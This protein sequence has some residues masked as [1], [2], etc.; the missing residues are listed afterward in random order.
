MTGQVPAEGHE[1]NDPRTA[2][3]TDVQPI[4]KLLAPYLPLS[5]DG[6]GRNLSDSDVMTD[7][8]DQDLTNEKP[9]E[10]QGFDASRRVE[11]DAV[12]NAPRWTR[13]I[14][15]LIKSQLLCQ[16]S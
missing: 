13:T 16:L 8:H 12:G 4:E 2:T 3:G 7:L 6:N 11:S 1:E 15:P 14:N 9:L 10:N 5:G